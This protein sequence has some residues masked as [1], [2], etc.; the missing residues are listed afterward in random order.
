MQDYDDVKLPKHYQLNKPCYEVRDVINDRLKILY[1]SQI[2][3]EDLLYDYANS[4]KYLLRWPEK[5][6]EKDLRKAHECIREM[7]DI[8]DKRKASTDKLK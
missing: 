7:L 2:N 1:E 3:E 5:G 6:G 4:I 8:L